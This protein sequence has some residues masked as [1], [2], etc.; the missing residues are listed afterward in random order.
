MLDNTPGCYGTKEFSPKS[1]ICRGCRHRVGC[2]K[3]RMKQLGEEENE[4]QN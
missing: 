1:G 3:I 4:Q 2:R